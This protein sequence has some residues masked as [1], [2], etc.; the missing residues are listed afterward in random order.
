MMIVAAF[1]KMF[2]ECL[3]RPR[4]RAIALAEISAFSRRYP[5]GIRGAWSRAMAMPYARLFGC[6]LVATGMVG[7]VQ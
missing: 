2:P 4:K 6:G 7:E 1:P 3:I 5:F